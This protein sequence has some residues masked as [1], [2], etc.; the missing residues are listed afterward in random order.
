MLDYL[1]NSMD[2]ISDEHIMEAVNYEPKVKVLTVK[3]F[4][5]VAAC[6]IAIAV[7]VF[8]VSRFIKPD[9][10]PDVTTDTYTSGK[11]TV[12]AAYTT[13]RLLTTFVDG[14]F[15][16]EP[17]EERRFTSRFPTVIYCGKEYGTNGGAETEAEKISANLGEAEITGTDYDGTEYKTEV[18][19][20]EIKGVSQ[21]CAIAVQYKEESENK[22][23]VF[24]DRNYHPETLGEIASKMNFSENLI[25]NNLIEYYSEKGSSTT[26]K[27]YE[28]D[29]DVIEKF[30]EILGENMN[31]KGE[32]CDYESVYS[33]EEILTIH[34]EILGGY[35]SF[36]LTSQGKLC[37]GMMNS[38]LCYN[39]GVEVY[40]EFYS[41]LE[42]K[43]A[44]DEQ[45]FNMVTVHTTVPPD[46][47][48][49][50]TEAVVTATT[51]APS[52]LPSSA[53]NI[54]P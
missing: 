22:Y 31:V 44:V 5:T 36:K 34:A 30:N 38:P 49:P 45:T 17:W 53:Y 29:S 27:R 54:V 33:S 47:K 15:P 24:V 43:G 19:F 42:S 14:C 13:T 32:S 21:D 50:Q 51:A 8:A 6:L 41:L 46:N 52:C 48:F 20:Y 37:F 4:L 12:A 39:V 25:F 10:T 18:A 7:S 23:Y 16:A 28:P 35:Y 9:I 11:T 26:M 40:D 2:E 1:L 3:R